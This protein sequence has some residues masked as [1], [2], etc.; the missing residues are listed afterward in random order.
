MTLQE[1]ATGV[2]HLDAYCSNKQTMDPLYFSQVW[3]THNCFPGF[4]SDHRTLN[5]KPNSQYDSHITSPC[6]AYSRASKPGV[7]IFCVVAALTSRK[8]LNLSDTWDDI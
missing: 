2:S 3:R 8:E 6:M 5:R 4:L 7:F 1:D